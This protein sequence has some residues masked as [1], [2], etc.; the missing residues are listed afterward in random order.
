[1]PRRQG[2]AVGRPRGA[3]IWKLGAAASVGGLLFVGVACGSDSGESSESPEASATTAALAT[4]SD[5]PTVAAAAAALPA[6]DPNQE[7]PPDDVGTIR[8]LYEP[9]LATMGLRLTRALLFDTTNDGY[10]PSPSGTHLALYVEPIDDTYSNADF[11]DGLWDTAAVFTPDVFARW[12][13]LESYDICQEPPPGVDDAV[14][15]LPYSQINLTRDIAETIDWATGD[16]SV[17]IATARTSKDFQLIVARE[18]R[19]TPEYKAANQTATELV[20][21]GSSTTTITSGG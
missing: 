10:G 2:N 6:A 12:S 19:E 16:T 17:L 14:E 5:N 9:A 18:I 4:T 11:V 7:L 3:I 8:R 15:P 21:A 1:M 13:G 20:R